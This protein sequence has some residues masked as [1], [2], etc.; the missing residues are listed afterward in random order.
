MSVISTRAE[1]LNRSMFRPVARS[2]AAATPIAS[3]ATANGFPWKLT[4]GEALREPVHR[5]LELVVRIHRLDEAEAQSV[6]RAD[7]LRSHCQPARAAHADQLREAADPAA[8]GDDAELHLR[9]RIPRR[10]CCEPEVARQRQLKGAAEARSLMGDD[11]RLFDR[12]DLVEQALS[13]SVVPSVTRPMRIVAAT[14]ELRA[15]HAGREVAATSEDQQRLR[16]RSARPA[17]RRSR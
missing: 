11:H 1:L 5:F 16:C 4:A 13:E 10:R 8:S 9:Q 2:V 15:V 14:R 17:R 3:L 12:L 6:V 7:F